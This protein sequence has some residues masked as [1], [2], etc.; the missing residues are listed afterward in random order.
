MSVPTDPPYCLV[1]PTSYVKD[2]DLDHFD[3]R[4][5]L[6]GMHLCH[7]I[8]CTTLQFS[9]NDPKEHTSY[10]GSCLIL[11]HRVQYNDWL[12]PAILEPHNH[13]GLLIDPAT[14]EPYPMEMVG[15]FK[16]ADPIFKGC[17]RDSL[18]YS[19]ADLCW[20]K[21]QG[22]Y[23]PAFQGEIPMPLAPSYRQVREHVATKQ[24]PQRAAA[25]DAPAESPKAKH[26]NSKSGP[27]WGS[28]AAP[29]PQL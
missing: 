28:D 17:Y 16:A 27:P 23:L 24:S 26:S 14:G 20:L 25:S 19:N 4:N 10:V 5:N 2:V 18:L 1:Y 11:P 15:N 7:C 29:T 22:I 21:R 9:N 6:A 13:S 12:F 8:C 3:T